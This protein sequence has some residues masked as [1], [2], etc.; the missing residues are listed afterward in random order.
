MVNTVFE[1]LSFIG[2]P[3]DN[4]LKIS[5]MKKVTAMSVEKLTEKQKDVVCM[6]FMMGLSVTQIAGTLGVAKSTVSR[7]LARANRRM[8]E[9][10]DI[11]LQL[12]DT[13]VD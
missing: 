6:Y 10:S 3:G 11:P 9:Y 2:R 7:T 1:E 12:I 13:I 4:S 5:L 8:A